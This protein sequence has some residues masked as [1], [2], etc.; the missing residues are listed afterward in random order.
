[1]KRSRVERGIQNAWRIVDDLGVGET[2]STPQP[3]GVVE[4]LRRAALDPTTSLPQLYIKINDLRQY[5]FITTDHAV[6]QFSVNE[7]NV[8][9]VYCPNPFI[10]EGTTSIV[11]LRGLLEEGLIDEEAYTQVLESKPIDSRAP[12][13]RYEY[14]PDQYRP[15]KHPCAHLHIGHHNQGRCPVDRVWTPELFTFFIMKQFY[16][17]A[18]YEWEGYSESQ[19]DNLFETRLASERQGC[20][21]LGGDEFTLDEERLFKMS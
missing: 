1:M 8:R 18:W 15:V 14:A 10:N 9:Y 11:K 17:H 7:P 20:V 12:L 3:L 4:E 5:N 19:Y 2:L 21:V 6:F 16:P 13:I